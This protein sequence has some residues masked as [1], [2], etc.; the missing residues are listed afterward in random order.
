[1]EE[2]NSE[3]MS[4]NSSSMYGLSGSE[5]M[6]RSESLQPKQPILHDSLYCRDNPRETFTLKDDSNKSNHHRASHNVTDKSPTT[7]DL[8]RSLSNKNLKS[9]KSHAQLAKTA[10]GVR[11]LARNLDRATIHL[12]LRSVMLITKAR[13]NSLV[14]LTKEVAEWLLTINDE[15]QVYVDYHLETSKRFDANGLIHDNPSAKGRLKYWTKKLIRENPDIFDLVITLG[16]DGT[17]LYASTLFQRVVPPVMAFSLGSLGFLTTFPFENFRSILSNVIKNG[18]RTNL[19]MRFTCRVH[20]AEGDLICE[21]QVLNELTVDRGP[22]PWVSMLELYGDGSLLTVAQADGLIIATPTGSTAYS[23]SAGG[24]L[25]HPGVSAISVTPICPHTLSFRPIL[26]PD[27]MSL[28]VKVPIRS[29]ATAWASFD[30]RSRVELLKGYYV[31][32]CA[33]PFPFPTVRSS[34]TEYIDSVSRVLNWNNR[35]EQKSFIHLLSDKN[36]KSYNTYHRRHGSSPESDLED[37]DNLDVNYVN[38]SKEKNEKQHRPHRP[39][40]P[41]ARF[42]INDEHLDEVASKSGVTKPSKL[43]NV[44]KSEDFNGPLEED[45]NEREKQDLQD[46]LA[47]N[48]EIDYDDDS[49]DQNASNVVSG[50]AKG[51][52]K[53]PK[54]KCHLIQTRTRRTVA[55]EDM[56]DS[57]VDIDDE[58]DSQ[59]NYFRPRVGEEIETPVNHSPGLEPSID[60]VVSSHLFD[61]DLRSKLFRLNV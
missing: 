48:F 5:H 26:L 14:Y 4:S 57:T 56:S 8:F 22:S 32:V 20:T 24:S 45:I 46:E 51:K 33:S 6:E 19:R 40:A 60:Q 10:H 15:T 44:I 12:Q 50:T 42:M 53:S 31:T 34:K 18:V 59:N 58:D 9:V 28:K 47:G 25:V 7:D 41:K 39:A 61:E 23:L 29:R 11:I 38:Q 54:K 2:F 52:E 13:D 36:K 35:E 17:V 49:E 3:A 27:T 21:Q 16:G 1:M 43:K 55:N 37:E 30:G